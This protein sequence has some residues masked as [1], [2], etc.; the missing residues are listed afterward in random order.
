[1]AISPIFRLSDPELRARVRAQHTMLQNTHAAL[2]QWSK[3]LEEQS[4]RIKQ[5]TQHIRLMYEDVRRF[6]EAVESEHLLCASYKSVLTMLCQIAMVLGAFL[7]GTWCY[8][9]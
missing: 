1:M 5:Q 2:V 8:S 7:L 4:T 6:Q 9:A 3:A